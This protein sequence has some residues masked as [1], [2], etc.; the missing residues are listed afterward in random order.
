MSLHVLSR[1]RRPAVA[2]AVA[3]IVVLAAGAPAGAVTFS[4]IHYNPGLDDPDETLEF[5]EIY[6][7]GST[8]VDLSGFFFADGIEFVF[9]DGTFLESRSY[10][11][12]CRDEQ[13]VQQHFGI[14]NTIGNFEG[15]LDN[16]GERIVLANPAGARVLVMEYDDRGRWPAGADGTGYTL[17]IR[18]PL[19]DP[20]AAASW[21]RSSQRGGT[22]GITNFPPPLFVDNEIMPPGSL[23]RY[24]KGWDEAAQQMAE[25]SDPPTAWHAPDFDDASWA[26]GRSPIGFGED[27]IVTVLEDMNRNY[28]AF[29]ARTRFT[30][31]QEQLDVAVSLALKLNV[32]DG[33]VAYLN[34]TEIV[35]ARVP[36]EPGEPVPATADAS[37]SRELSRVEEFTLPAEAFLV[38]E[39]VLA[40]QV[41]NRRLTSTDAGLDATM[42]YRTIRTFAPPRDSS[43]VINEISRAGSPDERF[44]ELH[45][46]TEEDVDLAG[47]WITD[48]ASTPRKH[49]VPAGTTIGPRGFHVVSETELGFAL[50]VDELSVHLYD[51]DADFPLDSATVRTVLEPG[52]PI[53]RCRI[54]D[55]TGR[56][57]R[58]TLRTPGSVNDAEIEDGI[59]INEIHYHPL[60]MKDGVYVPDATHAEYIELFNRSDRAI[61]LAGMRIRGGIRFDFAPDRVMQ[62]GA[63]LVVARDPAY[64]VETYEIDP[65]IVTGLAPDATEEERDR[66]GVLRDVGERVRLEDAL[67]N[68]VD[69][70]RFHDGGEWDSLADGGGSSLELIDPLQDNASAYAWRASIESHKAPWVEIDY[71]VLNAANIAPMPM[72]PEMHVF[73]IDDG[74]CLID[75]ISLMAN[76][77]E[78]VPNGDFESNTRPWR[79]L[80][81]HIHSFMTTDEAKVGSAALHLVATGSGNNKVNRIE[82]DVSPP[83]PRGTVRIRMWARWLGGSNGLHVSGHNNAFGRTTWLPIP[84]RT[85]TP[86]AENSVRAALR[87][88]TGSD[89]LGPVITRLRHHP[90]VPEPNAPVD[91]H[92]EV[93]DSD[94][95]ESVV[96]H[97]QLDG[98]G[99]EFEQLTLSDDG[100]SGD[101]LAGDGNYA[102]RITSGFAPKRPIN[103]WVEARDS[104]G[105][106]SVFPL[107]APDR[108]YAMMAD[109]A[110]ESTVHL[111]R[112]I[113]N[114]RNN[115]ELTTRQLHSNDLVRGTFVFEES[116]VHYDVGYRYHGSPWNRPPTPRMYRVRFS[117]D[118]LFRH[119]AKRFNISRYGRDQKEGT[120][121][122][123][124]KKASAPG[125]QVTYSEPYEYAAVSIN[126]RSLA[127]H[128]MA[129]IR[130]VD[131]IYTDLHWPGDGDGELWKIT[132]KIAFND[133][134]TQASGSPDWTQFRLY[135]TGAVVYPGEASPENHRFYYHP[136]LDRTKDSFA[137]LIEMLSAM[138][139][140]STPDAEYEER[141]E[142]II[143]VEQFLRTHCTR[144]LHDDWDTIDI[145][146]GQNAYV[147]Y[148]PIEG[149]H[150]LVP[151]DLDHTW[152]GRNVA[153]VPTNVVFGMGRLVSRPPFRR[154]YMSI[155]KEIL[156]GPW[157]EDYITFWTQSISRT[158]RPPLTNVGPVLGYS[159]SRRVAAR[160]FLR[161]GLTR[162]FEISTPSPAATPT[163]EITIEGT[164]PLDVWS[165]FVFDA[166]GTT[167]D[168][169]LRWQAGNVPVNWELDIRGIERGRNLVDVFGFTRDGG[170]VEFLPFEIVGTA[171]WE[172][173][174]VVA[175]EP[176][177]GSTGGGT[178]VA[179]TG[180][181]FRPDA[182]VTFGDV[183]AE[184]ASVE[185]MTEIRAV[186]PAHEAGLVDVT[187]TNIDG[188]SGS[189]PGAF[190]F[191]EI[192]FVRGDVTR[193]GR[194]NISDVVSILR[195]LFQGLEE[196]CADAV[197]VNDSGTTDVTDAIVLLDFIFMRGEPPAAPFPDPGIDP[198]AD[199]LDCRE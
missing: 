194:L 168:T 152:E 14:E 62:P 11:V 163:R 192:P 38:G 179:I 177:R 57:L 47:L 103:F 133:G 191:G 119:T 95:V 73:L 143:N 94:G 161:V 197:D 89:N 26:E 170:L 142:Q 132:G 124:L 184:S 92:V 21:V 182:V 50:D 30:V 100:E 167:M 86:G 199:D 34:G 75:G 68:P 138:D 114:G 153:L 106:S 123:M 130:A 25:F 97:Y 24:R 141:I 48:D 176:T 116:K 111:H 20:D 42:I 105:K 159:R 53:V 63:Y 118:S 131:G 36:G 3:A 59:V 154:M 28:V 40:V 183:E 13:A 22:P 196:V 102:G 54:P 147:Y 120:A 96:V 186:T 135:S 80:G 109:T 41:H 134:G 70:V 127:S 64:I 31:E 104:I 1:H 110:A 78:F 33:V 65:A 16:A 173:P 156:D 187:V 158:A 8:I 115:R 7:Q 166:D 35:R 58:S 37:G 149:R 44:V 81:N 79:I 129:E 117:S 108:T 136:K 72:E 150:Y 93:S 69:E 55:G 125:A 90:P 4:E 61:S 2:L 46:L 6:N 66:F 126:G 107:G 23:W 189:L 195:F 17:A 128:A 49:A 98:S 188:Q 151:W 71:E 101:G 162:P 174:R 169:D 12:L 88:E 83:I 121:Y 27:E 190:R 140:R 144:A 87:E 5:I 198:T 181:G 99:E 160:N 164:A 112:V 175:V 185:S 165:I 91:F 157:R 60:L 45:N 15:R 180:A 52:E 39:N 172:A 145:Q 171:D 122:Q 193:D 9:P 51:R 155:M 84:A 29:A 56:W 74:E 19:A 148:A 85:G 137:P 67:D 113:I 77:R 178:E 139:R 43:V 82:T 10:L 146:N 32:D 76:E 18:D